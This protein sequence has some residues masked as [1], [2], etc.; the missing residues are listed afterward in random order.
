[1]SSGLRDP[2]LRQ[3]MYQ[4]GEL[5]W[6]CW[7]VAPDARSVRM[8]SDAPIRHLDQS[9][10]EAVQFLPQKPTSRNRL[11]A[12]ADRDHLSLVGESIRC[13]QHRHVRLPACHCRVQ[14]SPI[15]RCP[16][17]DRSAVQLRQGHGIGSNDRKGCL[18]FAVKTKRHHRPLQVRRARQTRSAMIVLA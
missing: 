11:E 16:V 17:V 9:I 15:L 18:E 5:C 8:P 1:M 7:M 12:S 4:W 2:V 3:Q 14:R 10:S 6:R 13:L